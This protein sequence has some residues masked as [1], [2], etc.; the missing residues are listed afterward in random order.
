MAAD[1]VRC[2]RDRGESVKGGHP[3]FHKSTTT[4]RNLPLP[5]GGGQ[6][7]F[8]SRAR[9]GWESGA[10]TPTP[11]APGSP[12]G[13]RRTSEG[14]R[15]APGGP[16]T[17]PQLQPE[18][19]PNATPDQGPVRR[20]LDLVPTRGPAFPGQ[21]AI[22]CWRRLA[23]RAKNR[24]QRTPFAARVFGGMCERGDSPLSQK[25]NDQSE[26]AAARR[27]RARKFRLPARSAGRFGSG[28]LT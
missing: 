17:G 2:P 27:R 16:R 25:S 26:L 18:P 8:D 3:R 11:P 15:E 24:W 13:S 5:A 21:R 4:N 14:R 12:C 28:G 9:S 19:R 7:S 23:E 22:C 10:P 1:S 20:P 6:G